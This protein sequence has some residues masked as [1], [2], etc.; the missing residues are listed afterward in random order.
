MLKKRR[1]QWRRFLCTALDFETRRSGAQW[2][3]PQWQTALSLPR[4]RTAKPRESHSPCP[5][6]SSPPGDPARK[7]KNEAACVAS[8]ARIAGFAHHRVGLDQKKVAQLP[9]LRTTLLAPDLED[10]TSTILELD[11][12]WSFVLKK[13]HDSWIWI[14]LCRKSRQVVAYAVGDRSRQDVSAVVGSH[15]RRVSAGALR[16]V[17]LGGLHGDDP[18]G[19][20]HSRGQ[21]D[22]RNG[23]RGALEH[24]A[25]ST[26]CPFCPR[27]VVLFKSVLMPET[28]L[29]VIRQI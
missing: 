9:P 11:E 17:F 29:L 6:R 19:A 24:Y 26:A 25:A 4:V 14:A 16:N 15:S 3:C 7:L 20:T 8:P 12:L 13:A 18:A 22:W 10:S 28:G 21:R 23:S 27:D 5:S 2:S 1:F